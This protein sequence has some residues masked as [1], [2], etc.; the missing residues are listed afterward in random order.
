M[1]SIYPEFRDFEEVTLAEGH[2]PVRL[3]K[4]SAFDSGLFFKAQI[5]GLVK[6][7][8]RPGEM[9]AHHLYIETYLVALCVA[10]GRPD[11]PADKVLEMTQTLPKDQLEKLFDKA[12]EM[13]GIEFEREN[14]DLPFDEDSI[15]AAI[16]KSETK[17]PQ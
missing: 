8:G 15:K 12:A 6:A 14:I 2:D 11:V 3:Y 16:K 7:A 17:S 1:D 9:A 10:P 13:N 4:L 5:D